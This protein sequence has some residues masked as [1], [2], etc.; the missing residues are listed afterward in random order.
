VAQPE[1]VRLLSADLELS[2]ECKQLTDKLNRAST[3]AEVRE[4]LEAHRRI[5]LEMPFLVRAEFNA[6]IKTLFS[7]LPLSA[8]RG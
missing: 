6:H 1:Y 7:T 3:V 8:R 5:Y 4:V 2:E